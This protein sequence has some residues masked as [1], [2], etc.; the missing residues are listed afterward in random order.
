[1]LEAHLPASA[2][3]DNEDPDGKR[4]SDP[5]GSDLWSSPIKRCPTP[6]EH[7]WGGPGGSH[8]PGVGFFLD[9]TILLLDSNVDL[10]PWSIHLGPVTIASKSR[11]VCGRGS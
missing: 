11:S 5:D 2:E 8:R 9:C 3:L 1:M 10:Q 7:S 4:P 6:R